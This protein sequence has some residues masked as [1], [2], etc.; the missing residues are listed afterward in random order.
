[1]R[2]ISFYGQ[3]LFL[4]NLTLEKLDIGDK[5]HKEFVKDL[6]DVSAREMCYDIMID[7]DN[8]MEVKNSAG[9]LFLAKNSDGYFGY[10]KISNVWNDEIVLVSIIQEKLRGQGL[11]KIL[12]TSVSDYLLNN[13]DAS[14][15]KLY[16]KNKNDVCIRLVKN[17]G[18][19][20][21]CDSSENVSVYCKKI[22]K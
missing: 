1:M 9:N 11:G 22:Q 4:E 17:C 5:K 14:T 15:I 19:E 2:H 13:G 16:I 12:L 6:R 18:F 7:I 8:D 10:M 3:D 21:M 20:K